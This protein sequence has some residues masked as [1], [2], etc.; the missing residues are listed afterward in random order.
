M[1]G[2]VSISLVESQKQIEVL[3]LREL[4]KIVEPIFKNAVKPVQEGTREIIYSAIIGSEE[5][6]SLREGVL[7]W[8]FG[9]TSSQAT[10]TVEI[11]AG[12]VSESVNVE[13]KPI[14]LTG[15]NASG[16]LV[17]TVQPN[18]FENIPKISVP[19]K[20]EGI[21]P[22]VNDLLLKYGDGFVVF[23]YDIE[24]G[25]FDGSR[26]GEARMVENEGSAWGVS[27]G[28]SRVPPQYA[29]NPSDNFITRAIDNKDTESK[30]EKVILSILGKQ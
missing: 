28:L 12:G 26:S 8:D 2:K 6:R 20:T 27:S 1:A 11:F 10:N 30:I 14:R 17:I 4:V 22:S 23:D 21:P 18:S 29:G 9:L 13:L 25:S 5:M 16:G 24:Y 15:K 7:R 19:W 3:I